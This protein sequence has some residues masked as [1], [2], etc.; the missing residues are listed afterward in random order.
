[1]LSAAAIVQEV[2]Q[3]LVLRPD[4]PIV[5]DFSFVYER[6]RALVHRVVSASSH[7]GVYIAACKD[8]FDTTATNKQTT[9]T[10]WACVLVAGLQTM[11]TPE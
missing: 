5:Y 7:H 11:V 6:I 2:V 4:C 8:Q 10:M 3:S 9:S 1:M